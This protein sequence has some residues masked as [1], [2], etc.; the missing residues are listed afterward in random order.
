M[1]MH[2]DA[3][4]LFSLDASLRS[5]ADETLARS[6]IGAILCDAGYQAVGSYVMQTMTW[7][8]LDFEQMREPDWADHWQVGARLA[9]TGW[10]VRLLCM[11]AYREAWPEAE[12][13]FGLY[14]GL[15]V[16]D[17]TRSTSAA[18]GD[19]TVWK[20]DLWTGRPEEFAP[21]LLKR[22]TWASLLT[23]ETRSYILAIKEAVCAEPEYRKSLLSVHIYDAVLKHGV[24]DLESFRAWWARESKS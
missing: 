11:D 4:R 6:G 1:R 13:D 9:K 12:P 24:A 22:R 2:F 14:W 21:S 8:D 7:R 23:E 3:Q 17:P 10:C 16:A 19:P 20:L 18:P 5:E 15:R